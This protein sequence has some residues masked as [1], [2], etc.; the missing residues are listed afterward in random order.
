LAAFI[1]SIFSR[2]GVS[3]N[4]PFFSD[5]LMVPAYFCLRVTMNA[6][7]DLRLRVL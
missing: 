7:V 6:S 3:M 2:S 4:G 1:A 5:L